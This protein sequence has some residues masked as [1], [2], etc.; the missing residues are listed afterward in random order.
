MFPSDCHVTTPL[1]AL[2]STASTLAALSEEDIRLRKGVTSVIAGRP[3]WL[4]ADYFSNYIAC[5]GGDW[6]ASE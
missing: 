5:N 3:Y 4:T 1:F 6:V 2:T